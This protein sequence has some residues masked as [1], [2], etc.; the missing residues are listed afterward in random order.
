MLAPP[1]WGGTAAASAA[2]GDQRLL[3]D[4]QVEVQVPK[5]A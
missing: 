2:L 3:P 1:C 5:N 4:D